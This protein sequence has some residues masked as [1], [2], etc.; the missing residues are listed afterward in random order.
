MRD[1]ASAGCQQGIGQRVGRHLRFV[2]IVRLFLDSAGE[3]QMSPSVT[4]QRIVIIRTVG[5]LLIEN[6]DNLLQNGRHGPSC[7]WIENSPILHRLVG[8]IETA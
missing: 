1:P 8:S 5:T 2:V 6:N 3:F 7:R 4:P